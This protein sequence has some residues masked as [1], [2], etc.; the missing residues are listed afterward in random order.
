LHLF[1]DLLPSNERPFTLLTS[2]LLVVT[3]MSLLIFV[4]T[5]TGANGR[6]LA[7]YNMY[8]CKTY[9]CASIC[10]SWFIWQVLSLC[11]IVWW[12]WALNFYQFQ[13]NSNNIVRDIMPC[14]LVIFNRNFGA[15][16]HLHF[17]GCRVSE[18]RGRQNLLAVCFMLIFLPWKRMRYVSLKQ[19]LM[20]S[21]P[22]SQTPYSHFCEN[23][24][25]KK[26]TD[27]FINLKFNSSCTNYPSCHHDES[28]AGQYNI[29]RS[30]SIKNIPKFGHFATGRCKIIRAEAIFLRN[31]VA[32]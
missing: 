24:N 29:F 14:S 26:F 23:K 13:T 18:G 6:F 12:L 7:R 2:K 19:Q 3:G 25:Y 5:E 32:A 8:L 10:V 27:I 15:I 4:A 17:H 28:K 16:H 20:A 9:V 22:R 11:C 21:Y 30:H 1:S 31:F